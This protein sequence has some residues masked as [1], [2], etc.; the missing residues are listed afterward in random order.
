MLPL[1]SWFFKKFCCFCKSN[2][3]G[4][5]NF[6]VWLEGFFRAPECM[7]RVVKRDRG[8]GTHKGNFIAYVQI[9]KNPD[10]RIYSF[11]KAL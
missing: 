4:P 5:F 10:V 8:G 9:H 11:I 6:K 2:I 7:S 1:F 3:K